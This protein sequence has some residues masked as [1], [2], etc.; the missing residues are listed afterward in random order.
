MEIRHAEG[1][2]AVTESGMEGGSSARSIP[3]RRNVF[4]HLQR[5]PGA[6]FDAHE[7]VLFE[8]QETYVNY[9]QLHLGQELN[10]PNGISN[11]PGSYS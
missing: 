9:S 8:T 4:E 10:V 7:Y 2:V 6:L 11:L 3:S 5:F 1:K